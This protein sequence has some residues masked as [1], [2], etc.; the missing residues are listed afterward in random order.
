MIGRRTPCIAAL[1]D[2]RVD[3]QLQLLQRPIDHRTS[4]LDVVRR[5]RLV[6]QSLHLLLADRG[7]A[8]DV[9]GFARLA[10]RHLT[11]QQPVVAQQQIGQ[12]ARP[13]RVW[14][15]RTLVHRR[16]VLTAHRALSRHDASRTHA[17]RDTPRANLNSGELRLNIAM[18]SRWLTCDIR[19]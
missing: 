9:G 7:K 12:D 13:A 8:E 3:L 17:H 18:K 15:E 14:S 5:C 4:G 6:E 1:L 19:V 2:A 10:A 16:R 11:L